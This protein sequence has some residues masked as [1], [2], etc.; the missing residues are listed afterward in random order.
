MSRLKK[1]FEQKTEP[2]LSIYYTAGFPKLNDTKDI[3]LGLEK[4]GA[5]FIELGFPF[6]DPLADGPVIQQSSHQAIQNGMNLK[7]LFE[8][9]ASIRQRSQL[10]LVLMG[11]LNPILQMGIPEFLSKVKEVGVDGLILPDLPQSYYDTYLKAFC[12]Q[13][14]IPVIFLITPETSE[15]RIRKIDAMSQAFIYLVSSNSITGNQNF[16]EAKTAYFKRIHEMQL[17]SPLMTGFGIHDR[18]TFEQAVA[19]S[20]GAIVGS[21]FIRHLQKHG[22]GEDSIQQFISTFK[23]KEND[24]T[25]AS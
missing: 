11:Y 9:V 10:P 2:L 12:E 18:K 8:Q 17:K 4:A 6:S 15:E 16:E 24:R 14:E 3:A 5:D 25:T 13:E 1:L 22:V 21:A 19:Y 7:V 23:T 20:D